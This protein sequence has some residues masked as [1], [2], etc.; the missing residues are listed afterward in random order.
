MTEAATGESHD[1]SRSGSRTRIRAVQGRVKA[2]MARLLISGAMA[3]LMTAGLLALGYHYVWWGP[4]PPSDPGALVLRIRFVKGMASPFDRPV[5]DISVYGD[6]RV[7]SL[8][9][10]LARSPAREVVR[11]QRLT[12]MAYRRVYRDARLAGLATSRTFRSEQQ[13]PDAGPTV[14]TLLAGGRRHVST[15]H[16]GA[17]G[18]RVWMINRLAGHLRSLPH[19][20]LVRPP[21]TY[22]P[23]RMA[24]LAWQP[25]KNSSGDSRGA[26]TQVTPWTLPPLAAGQQMTCTLLA[27]DEAEAATRLAG[28]ARPDTQWRSGPDL[29][30]VRFRPLLPDEAD[31]N[32][33]TP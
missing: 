22:R 13:I 6:G 2:R 24:I 27:G 8:A 25:P 4:E 17:D 26:G 14:I 23:A 32:A 19:S 16:A 3:V 29:Y 11:D 9:I 1:H 20:D 15:V 5:P 18:A 28:S 12:P 31:C 10:D 21:T 30:A 33:V 7:L